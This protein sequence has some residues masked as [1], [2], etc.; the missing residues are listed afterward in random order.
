M[1]YPGCMVMVQEHELPVDLLPLEMY[2]FDVILEMDW[3]SK[4]NVVI[5]CFSKIVTFKK[6]RLGVHLSRRK[7]SF[8]FLPYFYDDN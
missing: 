1:I 4:H 2:D 3:L 6:S 5:D 8:I 7:K